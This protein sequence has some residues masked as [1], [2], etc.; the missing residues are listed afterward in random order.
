MGNSWEQVMFYLEIQTADIP[1][2][3]FIMRGEIHS[4]MHLMNCP[5]VFNHTFTARNHAANI[6]CEFVLLSHLLDRTC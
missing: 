5:I 3:P 2:Q 1:G 4:G 6:H